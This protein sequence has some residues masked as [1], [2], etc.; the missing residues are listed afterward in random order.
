M[1]RLSD[2][3]SMKPRVLPAN[4]KDD[5]D[6]DLRDVD[7]VFNNDYDELRNSNHILPQKQNRDKTTPK[8]QTHSP[9][10][11]L[12]AELRNKIY[13]FVFL[14]TTININKLLIKKDVLGRY[15]SVRAIL[16]TCRQIYIEAS[17]LSFTLCTFV[18]S[19]FALRFFSS[20]NLPAAGFGRIERLWLTEG[21]G[22]A[23]IEGQDEMKGAYLKEWFASLK[24]L[25]IEV[26]R[27][28]VNLTD[29]Q[30]RE[31][32]RDAFGL[33]DLCI[34]GRRVG[35]DGVVAV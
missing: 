14:N 13:K 20:S 30:A 8:N 10:L 15:P 6:E 3:G 19:Y 18:P 2:L 23:I 31:K 26:W 29:A 21:N 1:L 12:P 11:H 35:E 9:L 27:L 34:V 17:A 4:Q 16:Y 33:P 25:E 7:D 22:R 32:L 24:L 28:K 5:R